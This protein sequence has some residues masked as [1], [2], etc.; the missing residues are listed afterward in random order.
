MVDITAGPAR[1]SI[2]ADMLEAIQVQDLSPWTE[3]TAV[4]VG[5]LITVL[6]VSRGDEVGVCSG[7]D[8]F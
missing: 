3:R 5:D 1:A 8:G 2:P 6:Y 4:T 7:D